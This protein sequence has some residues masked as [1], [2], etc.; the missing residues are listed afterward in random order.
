MKT[1]N[2]DTLLK[3]DCTFLIGSRIDN[4]RLIN[5]IGLSL[6]A[7]DQLREYNKTGVLNPVRKEVEKDDN[8]D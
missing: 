1:F 3:T 7:I 8:T 4:R 5:S 6:S 2:I